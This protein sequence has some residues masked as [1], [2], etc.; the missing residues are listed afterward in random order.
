MV[1]CDTNPTMNK[2]LGIQTRT[3]LQKVFEGENL[4]TVSPQTCNIGRIRSRNV[5]R[6]P[7]KQ[8]GVSVRI[9]KATN[10]DDLIKVI[11][12][13]KIMNV[14]QGHVPDL[15]MVCMVCPLWITSVL[16]CNRVGIRAVTIYL[17][18]VLA[19][20]ACLFRKHFAK[21]PFSKHMSKE[22]TIGSF[23]FLTLSPQR[24]LLAVSYCAGGTAGADLFDARC[25]GSKAFCFSSER[26]A[27]ALQCTVHEYGNTV[28]CAPCERL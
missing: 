25:L 5:F 15:R 1:G 9:V 4:V 12:Q 7:S 16:C 18:A 6:F 8:V 27:M 13:P 17:G 21:V 19:F 2:N 26:L 22:E 24:H 28:R 10:V 20:G 11:L 23:M 14:I 3:R